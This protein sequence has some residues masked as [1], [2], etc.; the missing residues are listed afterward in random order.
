MGTPKG[1][2][3]VWCARAPV[4][5]SHDMQSPELSKHCSAV[6]H[7]GGPEVAVHI[8]DGLV[9]LHLPVV[10]PGPSHPVLER[11]RQFWAAL[12]PGRMHLAKRHPHSG[13]TGDEQEPCHGKQTPARVNGVQALQR[14]ELL[15]WRRLQHPIRAD[16]GQKSGGSGIAASLQ[17]GIMP[18]DSES[19]QINSNVCANVPQNPV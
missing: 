2:R 7:A 6:L 4:W 3:L 16:H 11:F 19:C 18:A 15:S 10:Q 1:C 17:P 12:C 14:R 5:I 9:S 8:L 13:S